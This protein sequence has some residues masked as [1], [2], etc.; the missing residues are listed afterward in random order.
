M[1]GFLENLHRKTGAFT[2][3]TI[4]ASVQGRSLVLLRFSDPDRGLEGEGEKLKV[5]LY[6]QQHGDEPSGKEAAITLA[7]DLATG[8]FSGVLDNL[9]I[10][11]VPQVNPDGSEARQRRNADDMDLNRDH[12][13][14]S[15]PEVRAIHSVFNEHLPEVTLDIHEYSFDSS[16][17]VEAGMYK[18]FGQQIGALSNANMSLELRRYAW[19]RVIPTMRDRL[20]P[21]DVHLARYLVVG[22]PSERFRYSTTALNDGRNS[23]GI[24]N[25]LSF[26][27]EGMSGLTV[28]DNLRERT[29][30]QLET[31]KAFV[32]F[33]SE[34]AQEVKGLV[35]A[36][37][38]KLTGEGRSAEVALV[39]DYVP[40]PERPSVRVGVVDLESG[41]K[42]TRTFDNFFPAV[43]ST[44]SVERPL[45]YALPSDQTDVLEVLNRHGIQSRAADR[46]LPA[47]VESYRIVSTEE[48]WKEDKEFLAVEV[49]GVRGEVVIPA[50]AV[51]VWTDQIQSNLIVSLLEPHS[52]W[53]LAPLP[54]FRP[55]L[56]V[57]STYPILR[58]M[59]TGG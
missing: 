46:P 31:M 55:L 58:I 35:E 25:S 28:E 21:L 19:D 57:G 41:A 6:A 8:A 4:G 42:E 38:A 48:S 43:E 44:L 27:I 11:L 49:I 3:D 22:D 34:N 20:A 18:D 52:Q 5:F 33:F 59:E 53:G 1:M 7:R 50:G 23:M 29:R 30:Q 15:T 40:D 17:W 24:Y 13:T 54:E 36:E 32:T 16:S 45:G 2:L 51:I 56:E 9:E 12:L 47:T 37:R 26:I 14:L 10:F 39:M